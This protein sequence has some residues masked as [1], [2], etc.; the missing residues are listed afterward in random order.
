M[1]SIQSDGADFML[2][3]H[4]HVGGSLALLMRQAAVGG[5]NCSC[6]VWCSLLSARSD[7][8]CLCL[9]VGHNPPCT[10][11]GPGGI[12]VLE[13]W[14]I[15][16]N[17]LLSRVDDTFQ[18]V[19]ANKK[20]TWPSWIQAVAT[21]SVKNETTNILQPPKDHFNQ[22]LNVVSETFSHVFCFMSGLTVMGWWKLQNNQ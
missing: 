19:D 14:Q 16:A 8:K 10:P 7:S 5:K 15:A 18:N 1:L 17:L 22:Q 12:Q 21:F 4:C 2:I 13:G 20:P 3:K 11:Q 9:G 6:G